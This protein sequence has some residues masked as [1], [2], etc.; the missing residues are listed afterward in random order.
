M[1]PRILLFC[2]NWQEITRV[3][4]ERRSVDLNSEWENLES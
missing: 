4:T 1:M 2:D 3:R